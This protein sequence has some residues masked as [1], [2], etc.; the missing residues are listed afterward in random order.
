MYVHMWIS[1][2]QV[3]EFEPEPEVECNLANEFYN[4]AVKLRLY[5]VE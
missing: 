5:I 2:L 4:I 3:D 1:F